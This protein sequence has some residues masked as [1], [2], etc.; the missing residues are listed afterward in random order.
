MNNIEVDGFLSEESEKGREKFQHKYQDIFYLAK[1]L[2]QFCMKFMEEHNVDWKDKRKLVIKTLYIRILEKFQ[3]LFLMLERGMIP[4]A[5]VLTRAMLE[6]V[7]ILVALQKKPKLLQ[8]YIDQHDIDIKRSLKAALQFKHINLRKYAKEADIEKLY[9]AKKKELKD[10][11]LNTFSP[12]K[13]A[14]EAGLDDFYNVYY[15]IYSSSIHSN[16]S[17]LDDHVDVSEHE[18]NLAFGPSENDLYEIFKCGFYVLF[19]ATNHMALLYGKDVT[20]Q[21]NKYEEKIKEFNNKYL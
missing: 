8:N 7:F 6:S 11:E 13:W 17:A 9:I 10:R 1:D 2:N 16:I 20:E 18:T 21:I 4:P 5:K 15:T 3:A 14:E 19:N 12:K